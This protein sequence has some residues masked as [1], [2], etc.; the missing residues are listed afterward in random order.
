MLL[1][2]IVRR[3]SSDSKKVE[4]LVGNCAQTRE[5][6]KLN[7]GIDLGTEATLPYRVRT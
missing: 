4:L 6:E 7:L 5:I 2:L 3:L 1:D